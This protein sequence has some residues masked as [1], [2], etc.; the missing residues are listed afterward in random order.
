MARLMSQVKSGS[1][2]TEPSGIIANLLAI[3]P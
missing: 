2:S 3:P 1:Q